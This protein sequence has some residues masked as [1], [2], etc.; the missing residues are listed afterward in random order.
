V[1]DAPTERAGEGA[2]SRL[3]HRKVVQWS[4]AYAAATWTLLQ[5]LGYLT[6]TYEWPPAIRRIATPALA[7]GSLFVLVLAWYHGEKGT[8][9]VSKSEAAIIVALI[10]VIGG[11]LWW[12]A[13][14]LDESAWVADVGLPKITRVVP[15]DAPSVAVLPFVNMSSDPEQEYFSDGLSEEILNALARIP[16]LFVPARTS[17]FQ[18]KGRRADI[19]AFAAKLGVATVL[20][21]SVRKSGSRVRITA[22]LIN[23]ADGHH[24]WSQTFDRELKDVFGVQ[25]EISS[26]IADAL[27]IRLTAQQKLAAAEAPPTSNPDAYAEYLLG[28]FEKKK[29]GPEARRAALAHFESAVVLDPTFA[30][31]Y[32]ALAFARLEDASSER[33]K[34]AA[35]KTRARQDLDR[36]LALGPD[37]AEVL[38]AAGT[39]DLYQ[40]PQSVHRRD[41]TGQLKPDVR[42]QLER[43]LD[44]FDRYLALNPANAE[45]WLR[46]Q[47]VL[48][49][50]GRP[51]SGVD[52]T[53]EALR[54]DPLS[55]LAL[56]KRIRFLE[57]RGRTAEAA[58]LIDRLTAVD[59]LLG[60][61]MQAILALEHGDNV[62]GTRHLLMGYEL[63]S[64]VDSEVAEQLAGVFAFMGLRAEAMNVASKTGDSPG[65]LASVYWGLGDFRKAADELRPLVAESRV[66][67]MSSC[68][69]GH[70]LYLAGDI[71]GAQSAFD[72]CWET[73]VPMLKIGGARL[74]MAADVA[75]RLGQERQAR[76]YY[77]WLDDVLRGETSDGVIPDAYLMA[78]YYA[79]DGRQEE[80]FEH[81]LAAVRTD[82][83]LEAPHVAMLGD[84]TKR[85]DYV[86]AVKKR[87]EEL[88]RQRVEVLQM[89]CG[90]D[91]V[92]KT[93]KPAHETCRRAG[94]ST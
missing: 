17:S 49:G 82:F 3:R 36:A 38:A 74:L 85:A 63:D 57:A 44:Y 19:G 68:P 53:A 40:A 77:R 86:A 93:Y 32:A 10:A 37:R 26:A 33:E 23:A 51:G 18:F 65:A 75:R 81:L 43:A 79:Y 35:A 73:G 62:A 34:F 60:H 20:E 46:R 5:I 16:G 48:E 50:L 58:P 90:P 29:R 56:W 94:G 30:D 87:R 6:E 76:K 24:L 54:R 7:L 66:G 70:L 11:L 39:W 67:D 15:T 71:N 14:R 89:L 1:T 21:G 61:R 69:L 88:E 47:D 12:Y 91:P 59:P 8:Q 31:A 92:S 41:D 80:A 25:E 27:K 72:L 2:L 28:R 78:M 55:V 9:K 4:V 45:I 84:L 83:W 64:A 22:Q 42:V 52:G 13:S